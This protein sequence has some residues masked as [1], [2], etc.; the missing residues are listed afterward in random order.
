M[1]VFVNDTNNSKFLAR[2]INS[3]LNSGNASHHLSKIFCLL[4]FYIKTKTLT[5]TE[6]QF[7]PLCD[8][9]EKLGLSY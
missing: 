8:M 4:V 5:Y 1:L 2:K 6:L 3:R 7:C 9:G